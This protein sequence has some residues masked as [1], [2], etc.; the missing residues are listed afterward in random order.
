VS[1]DSVWKMLDSCTQYVP[2]PRHTSDARPSAG[3]GVFSNTGPSTCTLQETAVIA[4]QDSL[5][6]AC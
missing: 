5:L 3:D 2:T 6:L 1:G 4:V